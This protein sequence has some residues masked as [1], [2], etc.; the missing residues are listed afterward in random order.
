MNSPT[1]KLAMLEIALGLHHMVGG[2]HISRT[3]EERC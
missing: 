1:E 2:K 3:Q